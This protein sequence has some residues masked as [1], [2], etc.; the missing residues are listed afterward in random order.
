LTQQ[1]VHIAPGLGGISAVAMSRQVVEL[2]DA[3][4]SDV[5]QRLQLGIA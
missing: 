1:I 3:K 5:G 2:E 4:G